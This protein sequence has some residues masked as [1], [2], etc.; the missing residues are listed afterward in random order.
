MPV[1]D[2]ERRAA[3]HSALRYRPI[4]TTDQ[5][6]SV[7]VVPRARRSRSDVRVTTAPAAPD[8][9]DLEEEE[10]APSTLRL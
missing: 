4:V 9:L 7:P 2:T 8:D 3:T 6:Y 1:L 10:Q 5:V